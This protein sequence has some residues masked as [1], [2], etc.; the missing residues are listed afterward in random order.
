MRAQSP[1]SREPDERQRLFRRL[2]SSMPISIVHGA[3]RVI[4]LSQGMAQESGDPVDSGVRPYV[5]SMMNVQVRVPP[6]AKNAGTRHVKR[7]RAIE[8]A[9]PAGKMFTSCQRA[10]ANTL[11]ASD[12]F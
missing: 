2:S 4:R 6:P 5:G 11:R 1:P 7:E 8:K 10:G 9:C 3:K 12:A